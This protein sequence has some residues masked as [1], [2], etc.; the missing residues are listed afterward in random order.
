MNLCVPL[1]SW[2]LMKTD[3]RWILLVILKYSLE[4]GFEMLYD[5][6]QKHDSARKNICFPLFLQNS[7][8]VDFILALAS[9]F[10][11]SINYSVS[12]VLFKL[13]TNSDTQNQPYTKQNPIFPHYK[14]LPIN[15]FIILS[16]WILAAAILCIF[17]SAH[18]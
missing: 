13:N 10:P 6:S 11:M 1:T 4:L 12:F 9:S 7:T 17:R 14:Y 3:D 8:N 5:Y 2:C 15:I 18:L 16:I